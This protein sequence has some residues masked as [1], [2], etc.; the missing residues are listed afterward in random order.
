MVQ[1]SE[2]GGHLLGVEPLRDA[3]PQ[4]LG[5]ADGSPVLAAGGVA[6]ATDVLRLLDGGAAAAVAGT[7]FLLTDESAAHDEYK[8]RVM[9]AQETLSTMLFGFG[10]PLRHRVIHNAATERWCRVDE[11]GPPAARLVNRLSAPLGRAVPLDMLG[12]LVVHQRAGL[13]L[14]TPALPLVG[15]PGHT[16][17]SSAL[18]AGQTVGRLDD[19]IPA[20]EAVARLTPG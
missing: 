17:D 8:R 12:K 13:P 5:V 3:L 9:A 15:M 6:D 14:L 18:Y 7:R 20:E 11:L 1:G 10:W 16:V 19:V 2:A 4:V